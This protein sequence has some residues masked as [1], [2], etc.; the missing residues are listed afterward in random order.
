MQSINYL[1][2]PTHLISSKLIKGKKF[3]LIKKKNPNQ[4]KGKRIVQ[5]TKHNNVSSSHPHLLNDTRPLHALMVL[6]D[7]PPL[8]LH[9]A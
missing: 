7:E 3:K 2:S 5:P 9:M 6:P 1:N 8:L 4:T